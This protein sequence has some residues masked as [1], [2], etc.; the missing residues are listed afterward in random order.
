MQRWLC[1]MG[2]VLGREEGRECR[3]IPRHAK[4]INIEEAVAGCDFGLSG[5]LGVDGGVMGE[6]FG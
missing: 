6:E 3:C 1:G 2:F 4:S 5:K